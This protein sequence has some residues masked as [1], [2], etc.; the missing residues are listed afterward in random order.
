[1][2]RAS[3]QAGGLATIA[4]VAAKVLLAVLFVA[5]PVVVWIGLDQ[6]SPRLIAAV[7]L[8]VLAPVA[9]VRLRTG[10]PTRPPSPN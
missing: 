1:M 10:R 7:L 3:G 4:R 2:A 9:F 8:C 6:Q 5:Y